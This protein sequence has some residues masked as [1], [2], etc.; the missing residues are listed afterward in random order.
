MNRVGR[1]YRY[2]VTLLN[3]NLKIT[4]KPLLNRLIKLSKTK[5][6]AL[7][8]LIFESAFFLYKIDKSGK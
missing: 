3:S 1:K 2:T 6:L 4:L 8:N 5:T 7:E